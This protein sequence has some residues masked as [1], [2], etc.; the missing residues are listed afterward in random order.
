MSYITFH[1]AA[2]RLL[3]TLHLLCLATKKLLQVVG[4]QFELSSILRIMYNPVLF[5]VKSF[6]TNFNLLKPKLAYFNQFQPTLIKI[7]IYSNHNQLQPT[8]T[9]VY[10]SPSKLF[11]LFYT[12]T[13]F[14]QFQPTSTYFNQ[15]LP[16]SIHFN[17]LRPTSTH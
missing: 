1:R 16:T 14:N 4:I 6:Y 17:R 15:L 9:N 12:L 13:N 8:S 2:A 5:V 3:D 10:S 11:Q 7:S